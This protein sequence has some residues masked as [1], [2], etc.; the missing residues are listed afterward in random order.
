MEL[1]PD[2]V[3]NLLHRAAGE[4]AFLNFARAP[5]NDG[6]PLHLRVRIYCIIEAGDKPVGEKRPILL[7]QGQH[8]SHFLNGNAHTVQLSVFTGVLA[9][10]HGLL[11]RSRS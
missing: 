8:F 2:V 9:T 10:I 1:V 6:L 4:V 7:R 11:R 5:V 3:N